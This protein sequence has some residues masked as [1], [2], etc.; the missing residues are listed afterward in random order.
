MVEAERQRLEEAQEVAGLGSFEQDPATLAIRPSRELC[1]LARDADRG[2]V[3]GRSPP[4]VRAS[5]RPSRARD[6]ASSACAEAGTPVDL[7]HRLVWPDGTIRWVQARAARTVAANGQPRDPGHRARHHRAQEGRGRPRIPE[8]ARPVDRARQPDPVPRP[9]GSTPCIEAEP[10][11][12]PIAVLLLDVDDFKSVN[13]A[14]GHALGD[15][16]LGALARRL[17]SVTRA[18]DTLARL[19]GD[20]FALL[21]ASGVD[22]RDRGG[23]R[24]TDHPPAHVA[25]SR[26][27]HRGDRERQHGHRRRPTVARCLRGPAPRRGS[28]DVPGQAERQGDASSWLA[29][30]C[31]TRP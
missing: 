15:E 5:R 17:A 27:R 31:R 11:T 28:G 21:L 7:A 9:A 26:C 10:R 8:V 4:G 2:R 18:G 1:R 22:A 20:E 3:R 30:E 16:L 14:L 25:V 6:G 13:D 19:G 29:R 12:D 23:R 24:T